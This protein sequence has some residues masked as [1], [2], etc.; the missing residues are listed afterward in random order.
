MKGRNRPIVLK[1]PKIEKSRLSA[2]RRLF[3]KSNAI[4]VCDC[5]RGS[6]ANF[7]LFSIPPSIWKYWICLTRCKFFIGRE[8]RVFQ[9]NRPKAP[10]QLLFALPASPA[11]E[12]CYSVQTRR[13]SGRGWRWVKG[14]VRPTGQWSPA[15]MSRKP[16]RRSSSARSNASSQ[17]TPWADTNR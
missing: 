3:G 8:N 1:N 6:V 17:I 14:L 10:L 12:A 13:D 5:T 7:Q 15:T 16:E 2:E 4:P 9:Q 11:H